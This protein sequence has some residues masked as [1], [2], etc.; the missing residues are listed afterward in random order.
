MS[1]TPRPAPLVNSLLGMAVVVAAG[2]NILLLGMIGWAAWERATLSEMW[3]TLRHSQPLAGE[4][5]AALL[6]LLSGTESSA[7]EAVTTLP[8]DADVAR[9]VA[10]LRDQAAASAVTIANLSAEPVPAVALPQRVFLI[11]AQG[12]PAQ[13]L[14]LVTWTA[15]TA[16][17]A[18]RIEDVSLTADDSGASITFRLRVVVRPGGE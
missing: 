8:T 2:L 11:R 10:A 15:K 12:N 4:E 16:P 3:D 1:T 17:R 7:A 9:L 6:D 13:L 14:G 18:A 5:S